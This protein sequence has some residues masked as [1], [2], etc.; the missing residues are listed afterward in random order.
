MARRRFEGLPAVLGAMAELAQ[1]RAG[2]LI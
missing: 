1:S 2:K